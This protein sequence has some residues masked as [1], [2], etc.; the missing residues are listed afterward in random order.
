MTNKLSLNGSSLISKII[1]KKDSFKKNTKKFRK[2]LSC[3]FL[4]YKSFKKKIYSNLNNSS[5]NKVQKNL[6]NNKSKK[7]ILNDIN[8]FEP[9]S[10][11]KNLIYSERNKSNKIFFEKY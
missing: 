11:H 5:L 7:K 8:L 10:N 4:K 2:E 1:K 6:S 3:S 9:K